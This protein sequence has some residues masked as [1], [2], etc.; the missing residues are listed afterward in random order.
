[1]VNSSVPPPTVRATVVEAAGRGTRANRETVE[2][3][4]RLARLLDSWI[5]IPGTRITLGLD[6]IIGLVPGI[7]DAISFALASMILLEARRAGAPAGLQAR[8]LGNS[9]LDLLLGAVP[10]VGDIADVAFRSN[11]ANAR[12][13]V[14]HL[15]PQA[16]QEMGP[17]RT[18]RNAWFAALIG[19]G[20]SGLLWLAWRHYHPG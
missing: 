2:R 6:S 10:V 18:R 16:A 20:T 3:V 14:A 11:R 19:L 1:M 7:G 15:D 5:E 12:L 9:V 8:M 4:Q 13:L 17:P